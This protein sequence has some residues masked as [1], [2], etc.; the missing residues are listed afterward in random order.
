[1]A[2]SPTDQ[3][4]C[5]GNIRYIDQLRI[6]IRRFKMF[7]GIGSDKFAHRI[8]AF[9]CN[10]HRILVHDLSDQAPLLRLLPRS[11]DLPR[12]ST[13]L[14]CG[15]IFQTVCGRFFCDGKSSAS[16]AVLPDH[17][18]SAHSVFAYRTAGSFPQSRHRCLS[19]MTIPQSLLHLIFPDAFNV[20]TAVF[21]F[22][23]KICDILRFPE[24]YP[25]RLQMFHTCI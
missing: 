16:H 22:F 6:W 9:F 13:D 15:G 5:M 3:R 12:C 8:P 17:Q 14:I 18:N 4:Q 2:V 25:K 19:V 7:S 21:Y 1:M 10:Q 23:R 11:T 20:K 24:R